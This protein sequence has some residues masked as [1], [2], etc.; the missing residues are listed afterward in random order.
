MTFIIPPSGKPATGKGKMPNK[1]VRETTPPRTAT[2]PT[3]RAASRK[4]AKGPANKIIIWRFDS[5][6]TA[7]QPLPRYEDS[8]MA[9]PP[10]I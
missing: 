10:N 7:G 1:V 6:V 3:I 5:E 2:S 4:P 9:N 8:G